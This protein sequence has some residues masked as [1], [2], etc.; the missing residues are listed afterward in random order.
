METNT[1]DE[2]NVIAALGEAQ[3]PFNQGRC[4]YCIT[5]PQGDCAQYEECTSSFDAVAE[6]VSE[7]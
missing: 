3:G 2:V 5:P 4:S 7:R 6:A 1:D